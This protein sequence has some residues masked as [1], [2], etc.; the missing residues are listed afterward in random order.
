M[1]RPRKYDW[2]AWLDGE[3]RTLNHQR[4]FPDVKDPHTFRMMAYT[5]A[6]R[7]GTYVRARIDG[8]DVVIQRY[9]KEQDDV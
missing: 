9:D 4:D 6:F 2:D 3:V 1:A 5:A 8:D 7:A